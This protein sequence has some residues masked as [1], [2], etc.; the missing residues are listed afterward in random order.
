MNGV[1]GSETSLASDNNGGGTW[2]TFCRM[3]NVN[4]N[5]YWGLGGNCH[6]IFHPR[7]LQRTDWYA[8]HNDSY[9]KWAT[10]TAAGRQ[11]TYGYQG[12]SNE[13][14]FEDGVSQHDLAGVTVPS[15][16]DRNTLIGWLKADGINEINGIP[17][18]KFIIAYDGNSRK[19]VADN[20]AGL[21]EGVMP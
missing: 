14:C 16:G 20:V 12:E 8:F 1:L 19:W 11:K 3:G 18:E 5:N 21:K 13:I 6:M 15:V 10:K 17:V 9:G 2:A 4:A 7:V